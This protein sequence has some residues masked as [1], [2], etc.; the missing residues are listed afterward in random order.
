MLQITLS[1]MNRV[2]KTE[3]NCE[4]FALFSLVWRNVP[5]SNIILSGLSD[6]PFY[7][8]LRI[9]KGIFTKFSVY[10]TKWSHYVTPDDP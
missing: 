3:C 1:L 8:G 7:P 2:N 5:F 9:F 4:L 6:L 10:L